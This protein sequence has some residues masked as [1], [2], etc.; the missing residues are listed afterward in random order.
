[1]NLFSSL[2][3]KW[4]RTIKC[5]NFFLLTSFLSF[6]ILIAGCTRVRTRCDFPF[7]KI[8][9]WRS[10]G[11]WCVSFQNSFI[12]FIHQFSHFILNFNFIYFLFRYFLH[13]TMHRCLRSCWLTYTYIWC[14]TSRIEY[15]PNMPIYFSYLLKDLSNYVEN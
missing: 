7:R 12:I 2:S 11:T 15:L 14:S 3:F 6:I 5:S 13:S 8:G 9:G 1:M 10:K 4:C